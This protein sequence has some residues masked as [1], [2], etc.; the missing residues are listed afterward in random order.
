MYVNAS[1]SVAHARTPAY[2]ASPADGPSCACL[3]LPLEELSWEKGTACPE[4]HVPV[5]DHPRICRIAVSAGQ[6]SAAGFSLGWLKSDTC[7]SALPAAASGASGDSSGTAAAVAAGGDAGLGMQLLC[8]PQLEMDPELLPADPRAP[9]CAPLQPEWPLPP[10]SSAVAW[11]EA[12]GRDCPAACQ[13]HG[14][15]QGDGDL[16]A[17]G[18]SGLSLCRHDKLDTLQQ[19]APGRATAEARMEHGELQ[20]ASPG[21]RLRQRPGLWAGQLLRNDVSPGLTAHPP[22]CASG[23]SRTERQWCEAPGTQQWDGPEPPASFQCACLRI[24][25]ERLFWSDAGSG[26]PLGAAQAVPEAPLC[27]VGAAELT[28]NESALSGGSLGEKAACPGPAGVPAGPH[29]AMADRRV[30]WTCRLAAT[31]RLLAHGQ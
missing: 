24:P 28:V 5:T 23:L 13:R 17:V 31:R 11:L 3:A 25:R 19:P 2:P 14:F 16:G 29:H 27:R 22:S 15:S 26:C 9:D 21:C 18:V 8:Q 6:E 20:E 1:G 10:G 4:G 7:L 12:E 30:L